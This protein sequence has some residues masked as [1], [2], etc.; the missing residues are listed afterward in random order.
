MA[1]EGTLIF[2]YI[3]YVCTKEVKVTFGPGSLG[4]AMIKLT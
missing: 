3:L 2:F 4:K 1:L